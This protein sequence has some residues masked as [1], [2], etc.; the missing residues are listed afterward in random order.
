[1]Q[2]DRDGA[3]H[4]KAAVTGEQLDA[5][6]G[7]CRKPCRRALACRTCA[8]WGAGPGLMVQSG[9]LAASALGSGCRVV[10]AILFDKSTEANWS[11]AWHQDR[12]IAVAERAVSLDSINWT[13]KSGTTHVEPP[14]SIIEG[15][16]TARIP[17]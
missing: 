4:F 11:L 8:R 12:T 2:L 15:L 9:S 5:L 7:N 13:V 1:M 10:R 3:Q 14:F 17:L 6:R 16:V